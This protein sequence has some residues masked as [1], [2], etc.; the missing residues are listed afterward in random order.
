VNSGRKFWRLPAQE[1]ILLLEALAL[2]PAVRAGLWALGLQPMQK[3]M[4]RAGRSAEQ[5]DA[6][7]TTRKA[8]RAAR[9]VA[10][11][12]R[13][14]GGSCLAKSIVLA[15]ILAGEGIPAEIR[16]G[17]RKGQQGFEAHSWVE[18]AGM[19]LDETSE[20]GE[21]Y[22]SFDRNFAPARVNWR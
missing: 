16:I 1:K 5:L 14:A 20:W 12:A 3:F 13:F 21:P 18:V 10:I 15:R 9:L 19:A 7:A 17:V 8:R 22:A 11:A 2:L 6:A 4:S